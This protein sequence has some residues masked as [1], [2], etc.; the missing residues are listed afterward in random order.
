MATRTL[1]HPF[2]NHPSSRLT[3]SK[4][5]VYN[6][7]QLPSTSNNGSMKRR[8]KETLLPN[9]LSTNYAFRSLPSRKSSYSKCSSSY[10]LSKLPRPLS[11]SSET[12]PPIKTNDNGIF[13]DANKNKL[14]DVIQIWGDGFSTIQL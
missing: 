3:Y 11:S 4:Y 14:C 7:L 2:I 13:K 10:S 8:N 12:S 5:P 6:Q 9:D 1:G